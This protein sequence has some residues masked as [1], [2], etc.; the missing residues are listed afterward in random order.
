[1]N[2]AELKS[3]KNKRCNNLALDGKYCVHCKQVRKEKRGNF[4]KVAGPI[5]SLVMAV[6]L[7][8][9]PK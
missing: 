9:K 3:C 4:L 8:K 2:N 6:I 5:A 7:K 1:M